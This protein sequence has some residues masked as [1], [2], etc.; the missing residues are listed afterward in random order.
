M[1]AAGRRG[2]RRS[3]GGGDDPLRPHRRRRRAAYNHPRRHADV[4]PVPKEVSHVMC[5]CMRHCHVSWSV[6]PV[7]V[8]PR[9]EHI[10]VGF[11]SK[12]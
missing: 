8:A 2:R 3:L 7:T 6:H 12:L 4:L 5:S 11:T 10:S 1:F 9:L